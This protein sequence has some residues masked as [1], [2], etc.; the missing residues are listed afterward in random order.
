MVHAFGGE[1]LDDDPLASPVDLVTTW[2]SDPPQP[3]ELDELEGGVQK[4][5]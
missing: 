5:A 4:R 3:E 1:S 2:A